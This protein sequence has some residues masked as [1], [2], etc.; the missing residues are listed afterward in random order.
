MIAATNHPELLDTALF[1][2]FDDVIEYEIPDAP[3]IERLLRARL[4]SFDTQGLVLARRC[5]GCGWA[6]AGRGGAGG[7][8]RSQSHDPRERKRVTCQA[9]LG[10][11]EERRRASFGG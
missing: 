2:R 10:A 5:R 11:I 9:L 1:R 7:R 8:G 3:L 6:V 4:G